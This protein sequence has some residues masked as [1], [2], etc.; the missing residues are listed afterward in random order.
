MRK[1]NHVLCESKS[2][3]SVIFRI[4]VDDRFGKQSINFLSIRGWRARIAMQ[5]LTFQTEDWNDDVER[6]YVG[7]QALKFAKDKHQALQFINKTKELSSFEIHFWANKFLTNENTGR[8]WY[9]L[10]F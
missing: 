5:Y 6:K 7:I 4:D 9:T 1:Y 10:Y 2:G 3:K 8:A